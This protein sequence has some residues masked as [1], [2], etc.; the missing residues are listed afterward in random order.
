[1][2]INSYFTIINDPYLELHLQDTVLL[3]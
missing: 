1:L 2:K 3:Q